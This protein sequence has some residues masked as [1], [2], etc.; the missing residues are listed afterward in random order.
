MTSGGRLLSIPTHAELLEAIG[1]RLAFGAAGG[2]FVEAGLAPAPVGVPTNDSY[3][4]YSATF[5]L[6]AGVLLLQ[7]VY[8]IGS[9]GGGRVGRVRS[10]RAGD[11][12]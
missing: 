12:R 11:G 1:Q 10:R 3:V 6:P 7:N 4:G 8:H 5:E 2:Q 9:P